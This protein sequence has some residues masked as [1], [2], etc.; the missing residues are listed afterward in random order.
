MS[1]VNDRP[2]MLSDVNLLRGDLNA[3][4]DRLRA[5][6]AEDRTRAL[7]A[8]AEKFRAEAAEDRTRALDAA[9][10]KFRALAAEDRT[11]AL[12]AAFVQFG[13]QFRGQ[14]AD[15]RRRA[16]EVA[17]E[18]FRT[19]AAG[20]DDQAKATRESQEVI[21]LE[22]AEQRRELDQHRSDATVHRVPAKRTRRR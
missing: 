2:A 6:A 10:E 4:A 13:E 16:L 17:F 11:R 15:D 8:A 12:D 1:D 19:W 20:L 3:M 5:E 21:A 18:Q 22:V 9:A 7:D 14:I